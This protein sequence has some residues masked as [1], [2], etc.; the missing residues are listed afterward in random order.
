MKDFIGLLKKDEFFLTKKSKSKKQLE[1][2]TDKWTYF[3]RL[4]QK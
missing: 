2:K 3:V 4:I 1:K